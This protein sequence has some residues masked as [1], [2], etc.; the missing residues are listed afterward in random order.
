VAQLVNIFSAF[1]GTGELISLFARAHYLFLFWARW[2]RSTYLLPLTSVLIFTFR[3]SPLYSKWP[4][5][6]NFHMHL[7]AFIRTTSTLRLILR[8]CH[9]NNTNN[10]VP[11]FSS[12]ILVCLGVCMLSSVPFPHIPHPYIFLLCWKSR[13]HT[14]GFGQRFP[15]FSVCDPKAANG[16]WLLT[17]PWKRQ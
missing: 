6:D 14:F 10:V 16:M 3:S 7:S 1:F 13:F 15:N 12:L 5:S 11:R 9:P 2:N 4:L 17:L 8:V